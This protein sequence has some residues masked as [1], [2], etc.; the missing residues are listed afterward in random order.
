MS[1][2]TVFMGTPDFAIPT[3]QALI[4]DKDIEIKGVIT[5]PDRPAG[6]GKKLRPSPVKEMASE[7]NLDILQPEK[8][9]E[10][11]VLPWL[12]K[13]EPHVIVVVAYGGFIIKPVR[14]LPPYGCI[15]LHP[16]K[17]P[18]YRGA[19]PIQWAIMNGDSET[20]NTTMYLSAGWD[21]GDII[22]QEDEPILPDDTYASLS[23][24]LS[25]KGAPLIVKTLKDIHAGAAP[26]TPQPEEGVVFAPLIKNEDAQIDWNR[27][28]YEIHN[29]V[30]GLNPVPG[31]FTHY[32][33]ARWKILKTEVI[34]Q[35]QPTTPGKIVSVEF[36]TIRVSAKDAFVEILE[37]QPQGKRPMKA[38]EFLRGKKVEPG[39]R[40]E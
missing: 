37:L 36:N 23:E 25:Q 22:Y 2:R 11:H 34:E 10:P 33:G 35:A 21:D 38:D 12:Q 18:K 20:A 5:Q 26:R 9:K 3:L 30:R 27:H 24:R 19:A 7:H 6:R 16:S 13:R 15:N 8:L 4:I 31:A 28:A 40:C 14:E 29:Q 39:S 32:E 1:I 17:L